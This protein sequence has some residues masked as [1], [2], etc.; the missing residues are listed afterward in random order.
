MGQAPEFWA[1]GPA[2]ALVDLG[3]GPKHRSVAAPVPAHTFRPPGQAWLSLR[4]LFPGADRSGP[5]PQP[6]EGRGMAGVSRAEVAAPLSHERECRLDARAPSARVRRRHHR[7]SCGDSGHFL[8][9]LRGGPR[10]CQP[11]A[12]LL[13]AQ[14]VCSR[15]FTEALRLRAVEASA[16]GARGRCGRRGGPCG[17]G[18]ADPQAARRAWFSRAPEAGSPKPRCGQGTWHRHHFALRLRLRVASALRAS[19]CHLFFF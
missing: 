12:D 10:P 1:V 11:R 5:R 18:D 9:T 8:A 4:L 17:P 6:P 3:R 7:V 14:P 16:L 19:E 13:P 2:D 15:S